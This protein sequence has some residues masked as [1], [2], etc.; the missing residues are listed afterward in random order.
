MAK[1]GGSRHYKRLTVPVNIPV[2]GRKHIQWLLSPKP[3]PH[4]RGQSMALGVLLRDV[5]KVGDDLREVK[6]A[7]TAGSIKVDSK[8]IRDVH[9]PIGLMDIIEIPKMGKTWRMQIIGGRL[10]PKEIEGSLA[11]H[12]LCKV[13]GKTTMKGKQ[14]QISLH[15]GRTMKADDSVKM[16]ATLRMSMP[17]FKLEQQLPLAPGVR[18]LIT[19]GKHAGEIATMESIIERVGSMDSES[20]MRS[21]NESFITVTKYLFVVDDQFA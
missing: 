1:R 10:M 11:K 7:I 16:G 19:S 8:V 4:A 15:D 3:G 14:V 6:K 12:K 5:L 13:V 2:I 20:R 18:C 17:S 21:G 9:R